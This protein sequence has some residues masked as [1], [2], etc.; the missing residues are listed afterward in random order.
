MSGLGAG[1]IFAGALPGLALPDSPVAAPVLAE[2]FTRPLLQALKNS[3][4]VKDPSWS[5]SAAKSVT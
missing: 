1:A 5:A 4:L 3:A 2:D